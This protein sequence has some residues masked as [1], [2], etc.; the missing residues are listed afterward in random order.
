MEVAGTAEEDDPGIASDPRA[1]LEPVPARVRLLLLRGRQGVTLGSALS[2]R[3]EVVER[4]RRVP[5]LG[6]V[7]LSPIGGTV[8]P[9]GENWLG[10]AGVAGIPEACPRPLDRLT[11]AVRAF[12]E[13]RLQPFAVELRPGRVA[14]AWCPGFSDLS[15][16]GRK[17]VGLGFRLS[18]RQ[19]LIRGAVAV[20]PPGPAEL[21]ALDLCHLA[22]GPGVD[23]RSLVSLAEIPGLETVDRDGAI[24]LLGGGPSGA[25]EKMRR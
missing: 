4:I 22:F 18:A 13:D 8:G 5:G 17:L 11:G 16:G 2:R 10:L 1:G 15:W 7:R 12:L 25:A 6:V 19:G 9:Q 24:R 14:G 21:R 3:P 20:R 23:P